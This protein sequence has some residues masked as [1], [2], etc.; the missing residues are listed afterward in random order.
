MFFFNHPKILLFRPNQQSEIISGTDSRTGIAASFD[1]GY[2]TR[3]TGRTYDSYTG[4]ASA[5]GFE[6]RKIIG[7]KTKMRK[8]FQCE[9]GHSLDSHSCQGVYNG[10]AKSMESAAAVEL[11]SDKNSSFAKA[12]V[13]LSVFIGDGDNSGISQIRANSS[14]NISKWLDPNHTE[15]SLNNFLFEIKPKHKFDKSVIDYLKK[16]FG[17]A[18]G[19]NR[20]DSLATAAAIRNIVNHAFGAHNDC[21]SWCGYKKSPQDYKHEGLPGGK[22][23][24]GEDL[25]TDLTD[26]LER[27]ASNSNSL[28]FGGNS[29]ANE[30]FDNTVASKAPKSR[31]YGGTSSHHW[32]VSASVAQNNNGTVFLSESFKEAGL[33]PGSHTERIRKRKDY[34]KARRKLIQKS[35][36]YKKGFMLKKKVEKTKTIISR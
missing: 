21:G 23:L 3:G 33:S 16:C 10:T 32:R 6:G 29:Q 15:K 34:W 11:M 35:I 2:G 22:D 25:R 19:Q 26:L 13:K 14:H 31:F 7:F 28:A 1:M 27:F 4:H 24:A 12:N 30:S 9:R 5:F 17:Y 8:C 20:G 18:L 36:S